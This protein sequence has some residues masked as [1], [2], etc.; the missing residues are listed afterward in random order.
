[1][2]TVA[3]PGL[4]W[5]TSQPLQTDPVNPCSFVSVVSPEPVAHVCASQ[6][7][8]ESMPN[9]STLPVLTCKSPSS[10]GSVHAT[11]LG[12]RGLRKGGSSTTC[13]CPHT[14]EAQT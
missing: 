10:A 2:Q 1:M 6:T 7:P 13:P 3:P 12:F 5:P 8:F 14:S 9:D 11:H 4:Y